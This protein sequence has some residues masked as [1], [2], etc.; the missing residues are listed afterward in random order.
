MCDKQTY[1]NVKLTGDALLKAQKMIKVD[2]NKKKIKA[3]LTEMSEKS[4]LI[5]TLQNIQSKEKKDKNVPAVDQL[6]KLYDIMSTIPDATV[7]FITDDEDELVG[8]FCDATELRFPLFNGLY[9]LPGPSNA[10]YLL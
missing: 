1:E 3:Y 4:V 2:G 8:K 10:G 9:R 5:K 6:R 7:C